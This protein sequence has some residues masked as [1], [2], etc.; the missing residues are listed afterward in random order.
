[1]TIL[2]L[3][4]ERSTS[5]GDQVILHEVAAEEIH[6]LTYQKL[7]QAAENVAQILLQKR[8]S[9]EKCLLALESPVDILV[10]LFAC[11]KARTVPVLLPYDSANATLNDLTN[12]SLLTGARVI[13]SQSKLGV[14]K[15]V[16]W[17]KMDAAMDYQVKQPQPLPEGNL[18][19]LLLYEFTSQDKA[20]IICHELSALETSLTSFVEHASAQNF[21]RGIVSYV[22]PHT[23]L[24]VCCYYLLPILANCDAWYMS[25]K[26]VQESP[27]ALFHLISMKS[28]SV[29]MLETWAIESCLDKASSHDLTE[30][31]LTSLKIMLTTDSQFAIESIESIKKQLFAT[32]LNPSAFYP[33]YGRRELGFI[34]TGRKVGMPLLKLS[35]NRHELCKGN[36]TI[37]T[38]GDEDAQAMVSCGK[39]LPGYTVEIVR[40][41]ESKPCKPFDVGEV[42]IDSQYLA[43]GFYQNEKLDE[44]YFAVAP[45]GSRRLKTGHLG[46]L[47][48]SGEL[49]ISGL[50]SDITLINKRFINLNDFKSSIVDECEEIS[51]GDFLVFKETLEDKNERLVIL[52]ETALEGSDLTSLYDKI[53][54]ISSKEVELKFIFIA[55]FEPGR[56]PRVKKQLDR[57]ESI[58]KWLSK[59]LTTNNTWQ[60]PITAIQQPGKHGLI[61]LQGLSDRRKGEKLAEW[62]YA[63]MSLTR[64]VDANQIDETKHLS[65]YG[66]SF[67]D[68]IRLAHELELV[69]N[70]WV[71]PAVIWEFNNLKALTRFL[72]SEAFMD[73]V[74]PTPVPSKST[75]SEIVAINCNEEELYLLTQKTADN[76]GL[77]LYNIYEANG[78]LDLTALNR[79]LATVSRKHQI[80]RTGFTSHGNDIKRKVHPDFVQTAE[81]IDLGGLPPAEQEPML[82]TMVQELE[83][84]RFDDLSKPLWRAVVYKLSTSRF[85]IVLMF[86]RII[87]DEWSAEVVMRDITQCYNAEMQNIPSKLDDDK[88]SMGDYAEWQRQ[89]ITNDDYTFQSFYWEN[90][91]EN[92]TP[93]YLPYDNMPSNDILPESNFLYFHI[94]AELLEACYFTSRSLQVDLYAYF[95]T[96]LQI[97]LFWF[98]NE[99]N[100]ALRCNQPNRQ[101]KEFYY[102]VGN[103]AEHIILQENIFPRASVEDL[104]E[105]NRESLVRSCQNLDIPYQEVLKLLDKKVTLS[106]PNCAFSFNNFPQDYGFDD[107]EL[108]QEHFTLRYNSMPCDTVNIHVALFINPNGTADCRMQYRTSL[109]HEDSVT[110]F[111]TKYAEVM[112]AM[113]TNAHMP[114][115]HLVGEHYVKP[116]R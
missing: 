39:A 40:E 63:W 9:E 94:N 33:C 68:A 108:K 97:A 50:V 81:E 3:C 10:G 69:F 77:Y 16:S 112:T 30:L 54:E 100:I 22:A 53:V 104:L 29:T 65:F 67:I 36:A 74:S 62:L 106:M 91:L 42:L 59:K 31:D 73:D 28:I 105:L 98:S 44:R 7:E 114:I 32:G 8:V 17:I 5:H 20:A 24:G 56:L 4:K 35:I 102:A 58:D 11:L 49:F 84:E 78:V 88:L 92:V 64:G 61:N 43:A 116:G 103:L 107:I 48:D 27:I 34:A 60:L 1:M 89:C 96:A 85:Y 110:A 41:G 95:A 86:H 38:M 76:L 19:Q 18:P 93:L 83:R 79:A 75:N 6:E 55:V 101:H 2:S 70:I 99:K 52:L 111:L 21:Q 72:F 80:L 113:T 57:E 13:L 37:V 82:A 90:R 109:F 51:H 46:F 12:I 115:Q 87:I 45:D 26:A 15:N 66:Y 14:I 47:D 23:A 71:R 25:R